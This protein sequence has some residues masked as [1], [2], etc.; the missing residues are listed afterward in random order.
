MVTAVKEYQKGSYKCKA[1]QLTGISMFIIV[2]ITTRL[3][4][5]GWDV[6]LLRL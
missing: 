2:I 3:L 4:K 6:A 1:T 5:A